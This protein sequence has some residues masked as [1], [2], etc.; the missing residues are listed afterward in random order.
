[1]R[2]V[3]IWGYPLHSHTHSYV[4]YGWYKGFKHLGYETYWF[5]DK[6]NIPAQFDFTDCLFITEGYADD[7][8]PL[9]PSNIYFVHV[10]RNPYKYLRIGARFID[11]RY[12][13]TDI[14]D[15]NYQY[16]LADKELEEV[17]KVTFYE[18]DASTL[19]LNPQFQKGN[20]VMYEAAYMCWATD[21]LPDEINFNDRFILPENPPVTYFLGSIGE[22]NKQEL[23]KMIKGCEKNNIKCILN[24]PW[25]NPLD[26]ETA[27]TLV[28]KSIIAP[29]IRGSGDPNKPN[30]TGTQHKRIGY[31]PCRLFKNISYGK[32][33]ASNCKRLYDLFGNM[34]LFEEDEEKLVQLCLDKANDKEYILKQM[35]WVRNNHTYL[36]RIQDLLTIINKK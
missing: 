32:L 21:L 2:K 6:H 30:E 26:F 9:H 35:E 3:I 8:I 16:N 14:N 24:N 23:N 15:C 10:G 34:I 36:N 20:L 25:V 4:H 27:K 22:G 5:D 29:D 19:D 1:M 28:Q 18:K 7:N 11:I 12:N 17:S 31:I 13:V 33:G